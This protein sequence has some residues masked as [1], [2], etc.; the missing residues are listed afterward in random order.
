MRRVRITEATLNLGPDTYH[1]DDVVSIDDDQ[2]S[3]VIARGWG[4]D[5]ET[6]ETGER[7][8]GAEPIELDG[9]KQARRIP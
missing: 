6:G 1:Q 5:A 8:P 2:A 9:L 3:L 4:E 7:K